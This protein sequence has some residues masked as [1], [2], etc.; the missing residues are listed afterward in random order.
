MQLLNGILNRL[1]R[2][3]RAKSWKALL[4]L[5]PRLL[6]MLSLISSHSMPLPWGRGCTSTA[7]QGQD[8]PP[9]AWNHNPPVWPLD[10]W[11]TP[12]NQQTQ[13]CDNYGLP[14]Q[15]SRR[16]ILPNMSVQ[17]HCGWAAAKTDPLWSVD[18]VSRVPE[19]LS[20]TPSVWEWANR[21]RRHIP[22]K[23]S[24]EKTLR[25]WGV[26]AHAPKTNTSQHPWL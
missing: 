13:V 11:E 8:K 3:M 15:I 20:S 6:A 9:C 5:I 2:G 26:S 18:I 25:P 16:A 10:R 12:N 7:S 21:Q 23:T 19:S 22:Y 4:G 17:K 1:A 24:A 14:T